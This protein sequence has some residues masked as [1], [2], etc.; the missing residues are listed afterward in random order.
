MF[1][2]QCVTMDSKQTK[3]ML[4][5]ILEIDPKKNDLMKREILATIL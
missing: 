5:T 2:L 4:S 1:G 3:I